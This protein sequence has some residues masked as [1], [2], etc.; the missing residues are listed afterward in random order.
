MGFAEGELVECMVTAGTGLLVSF[1]NKSNIRIFCLETFHP[2]QD[3]N[4]A[5]VIDKVVSGKFLGHLDLRSDVKVTQGL[6]FKG[7]SKSH[8]RSFNVISM[9]LEQ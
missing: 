3:V 7:H 2:L 5:S 6:M 8:F 9:L 1:R 4:I